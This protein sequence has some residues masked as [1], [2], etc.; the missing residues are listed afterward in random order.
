VGW[1]REI[2]ALAAAFLS[3]AV[4]LAGCGG[5]QKTFSASEF[6][7]EVN[8]Q[9]VEIRLGRPLQGGEG[10]ELHEITL[11]QLPGLPPP[12]PGEHEEEHATEEGVG[13]TLYVFDDTG[14]AEEQLAACRNSGGLV[15]Y[16]AENVV[17]LFEEAGIEAQRL[18]VAIQRLED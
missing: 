7:D 13:G 18:A 17:V 10:R 12:A 16:R 8:A 1:G 11:A 4:G 9:G 2:H 6:I 3:A 14:A 15:C 5:E